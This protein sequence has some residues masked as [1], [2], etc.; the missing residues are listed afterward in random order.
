MSW[1]KIQWVTKFFCG[2]FGAGWYSGER[3]EW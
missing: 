1:H 2:D 3:E